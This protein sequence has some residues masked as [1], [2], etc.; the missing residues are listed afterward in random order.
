MTLDRTA[1]PRRNHPFVARMLEETMRYAAAR[2]PY[3]R[4]RASGGELR[5]EGL[6]LLDASDYRREPEQFMVLDRFPDMVLVTGGT[7]GTPGLVVRNV[8]ETEMVFCAE[9]GIDPDHV[10]DPAEFD[11]FA[12]HLTDMAHGP[13]RSPAHGQPVLSL[14]IELPHHPDTIRYFLEHG[15]LIAGGRY[16]A[17]EIIGSVTK[18]KV[19]TAWLE[20]SDFAVDEA[21]IRRVVPYGFHASQYWTDRLK[22]YWGAEV[23]P[24]YGLT[25]FN[26]SGMTVCPACG[27]HHPPDTVH[28]E[29]FAPDRS[30][31]AAEGDA[32]LVLTS[33]YPFITVMPR[34]RYWTND[35]V[36][37]LNRCPVRD[38]RGFC[39]LGRADRC[40]LTTRGRAHRALLTPI[41]LVEC[42]DPIPGAALDDALL[43][44]LVGDSGL[45]PTPA[46]PVR[47]HLDAAG[48][49]CL[50]EVDF[51]PHSER[52]RAVSFHDELV[53]RLRA[54]CAELFAEI[55][56]GT[57]TFEIELLRRGD[58]AA[59]GLQ[60]H[61][62]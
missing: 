13:L 32:V 27:G 16:R 55:D 53:S 25:E 24:L 8:D 1:G 31:P 14:P 61:T 29:Y 10:Y 5:Y 23:S 26:L 4:A 43:R 28:Y 17:R 7:T 49:R 15:L 18:F 48:E 58:L 42:L 44:K 50:V 51:D 35:L 45:A 39:F 3:Y 12:I 37:I 19:L 34:L 33:L 30:G 46:G 57:V 36:R 54:R 47:F 60:V 52:G 9:Q 20:A 62:T 21:G 6:P 11:G 40:L 22:Q 56:A 41:D 59:R 38:D 2:V